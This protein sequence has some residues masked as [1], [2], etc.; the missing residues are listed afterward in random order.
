MSDQ[1]NGAWPF[2][3]AEVE[4]GLDLEAIFG[5]EAGSSDVN[6]FEA[7]AEQEAQTADELTVESQPEAQPAPQSEP[8]AVAAPAQAEP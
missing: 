6:P 1:K 7:P 8:E 5:C 4:G 2:P 3:V